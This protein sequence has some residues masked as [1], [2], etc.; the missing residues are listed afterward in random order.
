MLGSRVISRLQRQFV[1]TK[2]KRRTLLP[3]V[4]MNPTDIQLFEVEVAKL[5]KP[6]ARLQ[7]CQISVHAPQY[8]LDI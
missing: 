8:V 2:G 5:V 7:R 4:G 1:Q 3:V 6:P